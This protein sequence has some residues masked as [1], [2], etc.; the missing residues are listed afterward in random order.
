[1]K[2]K[3]ISWEKYFINIALE[4]AKR[5]TCDRKNV[6]AVII[7]D[8]TILST[9]YNGSIRGLPH[10]DEVGHLMKEMVDEDGTSR[11]HCVRTIHLSFCLHSMQW[12]HRNA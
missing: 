1:M 11:M 2:N 12:R 10:C 6:G 9:V 4:V 8:K 5:S 3:R 7:R